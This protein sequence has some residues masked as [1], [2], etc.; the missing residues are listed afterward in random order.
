MAAGF[1]IIRETPMRLTYQWLHNLPFPGCGSG[2]RTCAQAGAKIYFDVFFG[3][4]LAHGLDQWDPSWT[5][6][7]CKNCANQAK[8]SHLEGRNQY[9]E[10]LPGYFGLG[11]WD[12]L[13]SAG[14]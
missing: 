8:T 12:A 13:K 7:L 14:A 6:Q 3:S 11:S 9:W 10:A 2:G 5:K 1:T 4:E